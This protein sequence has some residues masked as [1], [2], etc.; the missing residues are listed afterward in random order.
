MADDLMLSQDD[1]L[2]IGLKFDNTKKIFKWNNEM[3]EVNFAIY[4]IVLFFNA[5]N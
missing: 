5:V 3:E 1:I 2:W 4:L